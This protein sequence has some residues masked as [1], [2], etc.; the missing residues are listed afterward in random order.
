MNDI[1]PHLYRPNVCQLDPGKKKNWVHSTQSWENAKGPC[2]RPIHEHGILG[3]TG[4]FHMTVI[5]PLGLFYGSFFQRTPSSRRM[6]S[7]FLGLVGSYVGLRIPGIGLLLVLR[8]KRPER[9]CPFDDHERFS[10]KFC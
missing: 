6:T 1:Y 8:G 4:T 3:L 5:P 7:I 2:R 10:F 9:P